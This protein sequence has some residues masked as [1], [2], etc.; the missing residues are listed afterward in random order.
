[1]AVEQAGT[2]MHCGFRWNVA[3]FYIGRIADDG[4]ELLALR[5]DEEIDIERALRTMGGVDFDRHAAGQVCRKRPIAT[6]RIE[7][8]ATLAAQGEH[9]AD[10]SRRGEYLPVTGNIERRLQNVPMTHIGTRNPE[11]RES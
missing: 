7:H 2:Q 1:M 9:A 3:G 6:R 5:I 11:S 8:P 4:G 10:N